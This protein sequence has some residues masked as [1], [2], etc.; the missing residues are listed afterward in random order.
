MRIHLYSRDHSYA[1]PACNPN[2]TNAEMV[3][4][5]KRGEGYSWA[6]Q[7]ITCPACQSARYV[8]ECGE[9]QSA[10]RPAGRCGCGSAGPFALVTDPMKYQIRCMGRC[11]GADTSWH[12]SIES[13]IAEFSTHLSR[14]HYGG[15]VYITTEPSDIGRLRLGVWIAD[16]VWDPDH[17]TWEVGP[18]GQ[19]ADA[20]R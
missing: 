20:I 13:A 4:M 8:C 5:Q 16:A 14:L 3:L 1:T 11:A 15:H 18:R 10:H 6:F 7:A 17:K 12:D 2:P 9:S 19:L